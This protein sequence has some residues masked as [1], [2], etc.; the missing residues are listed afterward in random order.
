MRAPKYDL[1]ANRLDQG[2][3]TFSTFQ[4]IPRDTLR[5]PSK[6]PKA[7]ILAIGRR[8]SP[9]T[10]ADVQEAY[11]GLKPIS[12]RSTIANMTNRG[13]IK[14]LGRGLYRLQGEV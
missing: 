3:G 9:F 11:P 7:A 12:V 8:K 14:K 6:S 13:E 5:S 10:A 4:G 2:Y 1:I